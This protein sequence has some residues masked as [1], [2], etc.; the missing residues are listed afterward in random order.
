MKLLVDRRHNS[1][2]SEES[3]HL[4]GN[5]RGLQ[6]G[7]RIALGLLSVLAPDV[8]EMSEARVR[9]HLPLLPQTAEERELCVG[10]A[11]VALVAL[12]IV[13]GHRL[14]FCGGRRGEKFLEDR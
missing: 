5:L 12:D 6:R 2:E 13:L 11:H 4:D 7:I 8:D 1:L 10:H 9:S 3:L 14:E